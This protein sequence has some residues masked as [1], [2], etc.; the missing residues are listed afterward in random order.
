MISQISFTLNVKEDHIQT[1]VFGHKLKISIAKKK[2]FLKKKK[3]IVR[4]GS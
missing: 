3:N 1:F 2:F 4:H